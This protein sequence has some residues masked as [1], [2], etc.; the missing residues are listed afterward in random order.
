[1]TLLETLHKADG[2]R[3]VDG[4]GAVSHLALKPGLSP[5]DL[6]AFEASLPVSLD[7]SVREALG[8]SR[9]FRNGPIGE[10]DFLGMGDFGLPELFS[11]PISIATDGSGNHWVVD[12]TSASTSFGPIFFV[13]HDPPVIAYQCDD[14]E[15]FVRDIVRLS[16][17][18]YVS[19]LARVPTQDIDRIWAEH[20]GVRPAAECSL[21]SDPELA[22]FSAS[23]DERF[24]VADMRSARPGDGFAWGRY[25]PD[26]ELRRCG[27][28]RI[29]AYRKPKSGF[30][31][32]LLGA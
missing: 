10:V 21:S 25:G 8:F 30:W 16:Q 12:L 14:L 28:A 23:L 6:R 1:M 9:G 19:A 32:R 22:G 18:P 4:G 31:R 2:M 11:C 20:P 26:A 3:V 15:T 7:D 17:P 27:E 5:I 13:S 24:L 29:F